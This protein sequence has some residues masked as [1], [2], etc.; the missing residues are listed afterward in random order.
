[1]PL[2]VFFI[3]LGLAQTTQ[4]NRPKLEW[5]RRVPFEYPAAAKDKKIE[6]QVVLAVSL[7]EE[8]TVSDVQVIS[9]P[10]ELVPAAV[11]AVKQWKA[12]PYVV[13]GKAIPLKIKLPLDFHLSPGNGRPLLSSNEAVPR[14]LKTARP[15]YP[16]LARE[17]HTQGEVVVH[18]LVGIDGTVKEVQVISG[19]PVLR[20]AAVKAVKQWVYKPL[21]VDGRVSEFETT[22]NVNF[23]LPGT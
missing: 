8:G 10:P 22:I 16:A 18:A 11:E 17:S 14:I 4:S 5:E 19:P 1:M 2:I 7:N 6:G 23:T 12:K 13:D 20:D 3:T 15:E 9:G 21:E